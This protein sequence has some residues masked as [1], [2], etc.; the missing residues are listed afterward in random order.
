[1]KDGANPVIKLPIL[2]RGSFAEA[3]FCGELLLSA[4]CFGEM[5]ETK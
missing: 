5:E 1:M 4:K 2:E 3:K